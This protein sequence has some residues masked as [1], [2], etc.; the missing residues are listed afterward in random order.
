MLVFAVGAIVGAV[1]RYNSLEAEDE[2]LR[3]TKKAKNA[4]TYR[5]AHNTKKWR[6]NEQWMLTPPHSL[7]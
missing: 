5:K 4:V 3:K 1:V 7:S 6:L 2:G